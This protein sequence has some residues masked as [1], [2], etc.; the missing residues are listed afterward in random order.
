MADVDL[1]GADLGPLAWVKGEL[2]KSLDLAVKALRRFSSE[3]EAVLGSDL[4]S[5]DTSQLRVARAHVHQAQ[6]A[7]E[8][9]GWEKASLLLRGME[10]A[11]SGFVTKPQTCNS[12]AVAL[13]ESA[14]FA[15]MDYL[16][17]SIASR[18]LSA[19]ALFPQYRDLMAL[20]GHA[21]AHPADLWERAWT[22]K[23]I[24][25]DRMPAA[26]S[27]QYADANRRKLDQAVLDLMRGNLQSGSAT[28]AELAQGLAHADTRPSGK[29]YWQIVTALAQA[30]GTQRVKMDVYVKRTLPGI[31]TQYVA[32]AGNAS[33][34]SPSVARDI[35][36]HCANAQ[37][38]ALGTPPDIT[39]LVRQEYGLTDNKHVDYNLSIYGNFDPAVLVQTRKRLLAAKDV[40]AAYTSGDLQKAKASTDQLGLVAE[41]LGKLHPAS[42]K[43]VAA[44]RVVI[45]KG[46]QKGSVPGAEL[47]LEMATTLLYLEA[48]FQDFDPA[49]V[50]L[51]GRTDEL[52][53]RLELVMQGDKSPPLANWME[54]LYHH[55]SEKGTLGSVVGEL[56]LNLSELEKMLDAYF[57][58][59]SKT[60]AL[61]EVPGKLGQ[62]RGVLTVLGIDQG[63]QAVLQIRDWVEQILNGR[64][65]VQEGLS[66]GGVFEKIGNSLGALGFLV[67]MLG[68]QP[69]LAKQLFVY[70]A[71][72]GQLSP[73]MGREAA[74][75]DFVHQSV[76]QAAQVASSPAVAITLPAQ[77]PEQLP[78]STASQEW[79]EDD[80]LGIFLEEANEVTQNAHESIGVL[81]NN[82][83]DMEA[84]TSLRR[85]FHTLKGSSRM[86]GLSAF[87][88]AAWAL[89][90]AHNAS[91][92]ESSSCSAPLVDLS[93]QAMSAFQNWIEYI[94]QTGTDL[95][96]FTPEP[97]KQSA[98]ALRLSGQV[99]PLQL[100]QY[101]PDFL[102][103][104]PMVE[105]VAEPVEQQ[106]PEPVA[107]AAIDLPILAD[108]PLPPSTQ[109]T[110]AE[111]I[112][113][114]PEPELEPELP[115]LDQL[116]SSPEPEPVFE[117]EQVLEPVQETPDTAQVLEVPAFVSEPLVAAPEEI[118]ENIKVIGDLR[119]NLALYNVYLSEADEWSRCLQAELSE[120]QMQPERKP[121]DDCVT[122][123][124][125]LAGSTATVGFE[126]LSHLSR[127]LESALMH[128]QKQYLLDNSTRTLFMQAADE[129]R[130]V[131]HQ[132]AAGFITE[133]DHSTEQLL[134]AYARTPVVTAPVLTV[135]PSPVPVAEQFRADL[136]RPTQSFTPE[137]AAADSDDDEIDAVDVIDPDLFPIF[138]EE[139]L[140]LM[141][142]LGSA[143]RQWFNRVENTGAR[144]EALR[145]MHTIKGS[146]RLAGA[147]RLG[148]MVHRLESQVEH[149]TEGVKSSDVEPI[150]HEFDKIAD[151][152]EALRARDEQ[153]YQAAIDQAA[154]ETTP[155]QQAPAPAVQ[156]APIPVVQADT[157]S[158]PEAKSSE[159]QTLSLLGIVAPSGLVVKQ[160]NQTV[161]VK[162]S[163]LDRLV[164]QAGEVMMT[165]SRLE[166]EINTLRGSLT[167]LTGN[168]EKLRLQLRDI[169]LQAE[170]QMQSRMAL[171]REAQV[172]FDPLEFDRF[173]RVQE[174]TRMMAESVNDVA[175]IQ[176]N[177]QR[178]VQATEDDL[179]N[180]ARQTRELQRDLLRT[181]M[182]EFDG[183]SE[184]LYRVVRLASKETGKQVRL[185]I[186]GGK[187]EMDRGVLDRMTPAFE[188]LLRNCVAHG[189]ETEQ[190]RVQAGKEASGLIAIALT[191]E[192]NDVTVQFR[193]DGAG[194]DV[195]RIRDKAIALGLVTPQATLT[196]AQAAELIF[197][198]GFSTVSQVTEL[199]GRGIGMDVVRA[200]V[201]ALGGRIET[202]FQAGQGTE[203]KLV[204]PLTTAVTQVVM[205]RAG[206]QAVGVPST[207]VEIVRRATAA[208][209]QSAYKSG[210]FD[211]GHG[212]TVPFYWSGALLQSSAHSVEP[213]GR[214][215]PVV[216]FRSAAQRVAMHVD[217]V[218][219]NQ[220]VVVKNLGPQLSRLPGLAGMT[221]LPSGA[222]VLIYNPVAL[223]TVYGELARS[224]SE[225]MDAARVSSQV[226]NVD[227]SG[228]PQV[229]SASAGV[230]LV[231]V[232]DDSIT[233]R[234]VTQ[235]LLQREGYRVVLAADGLQ[236]LEKL[237]EELPRIVL[238][239]IEMPR[240]DGFDLARNIRGDQRMKHLPIVMITSRMAEKHREHAASLGVNH[241]L[242]KP[243]SEE[244]L[245]ELVRTYCSQ[246]A[247]V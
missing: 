60:D 189:V 115:V 219:G 128:G 210:H 103:T 61:S 33:E 237:R 247:L 29:A 231:L 12:K 218:L 169:E 208:E 7:M 83:S 238:S 5:V 19:V 16:D 240:M 127:E 134:H 40:W 156:A 197:M 50:Q 195:A 119:I 205:I 151:V 81:N 187:I 49:D 77:V 162:A 112:E 4:S 37:M 114:A 140:E 20:S 11:V 194:L 123:A 199:A 2:Q 191:Q 46:V 121:S 53:Y 39:D 171:A 198:P 101:K 34:I 44:L 100:P 41:S 27:M 186:T 245:L 139:A 78:V 143:L 220:E 163:L 182:V 206:E 82:P 91:L 21:Q 117:P 6:G 164:N 69:S 233:V 239:D 18:A 178:S 23:P 118:D 47:A 161:R 196:D 223:A 63:S 150:V 190:V 87:G 110:F 192:G 203:F 51:T 59:T 141:P 136:I 228:A 106:A 201:L 158:Q 175:T 214:T 22:W 122:W 236:A 246:D 74:E 43:L 226:V 125:S 193:D 129:I 126:G 31:V 71:A 232:V 170:S 72:S 104:A 148:E 130:R 152:F 155:V 137:F 17:A 70:D 225:Q 99:I 180:Q 79:E 89:E 221:L 159:P 65:S 96:L 57:R 38:S 227:A 102:E 48:M 229:R 138:E 216:I 209:L 166:S 188:H 242:G 113:N 25:A 153:A 147:L 66:Q 28:L 132:F 174:L 179:A 111:P 124:H 149:L 142:N 1:N 235:R 13:L 9:V 176:R 76:A 213:Q 168:L 173:T 62:M 67:D 165:R 56:R 98:E 94:A 88:E 45:Q 154:S 86:V 116:V 230:P 10:L 24:E 212:E 120:L 183:I 157:S 109:Q 185:D 97:F 222:T 177:L 55:F 207:M 204:L 144:N 184:R 14:A 215:T 42:Q 200:E 92:A 84:R 234:K 32:L 26:D 15:V 217:E 146:A 68:Y 58:D 211:L 73:V 30:L 145:L 85:A 108:I 95:N 64:L 160:S 93:K 167:D 241:Y 75:T 3:A 133:V 80:L 36:F 54:D 35:L 90:Q 8:M 172:N 202:A 105:Q 244:E 243:Y 224:W 135:V 181:R 52:A 107:F 131:L